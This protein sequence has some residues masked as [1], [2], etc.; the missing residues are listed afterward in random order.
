[1]KI[2]EKFYYFLKVT[3][4]FIFSFFFY[5]LNL[6]LIEYISMYYFE[7]ISEFIEWIL[8]IM[9]DNDQETFLFF[10]LCLVNLYYY[11][12]V[13]LATEREYIWEL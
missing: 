12:T 9:W 8:E 11:V 6:L 4:F 7:E 1:M 2:K 13:S 5:I 3:I 10:Y